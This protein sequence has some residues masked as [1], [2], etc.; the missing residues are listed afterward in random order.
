MQCKNVNAENGGHWTDRRSV[1]RATA[2]AGGK[3]PTQKDARSVAVRHPYDPDEIAGQSRTRQRQGVTGAE[4]LS[5]F[6]PA[7][8]WTGRGSECRRGL[9]TR[10]RR[11][12]GYQSPRIP[13]DF[14]T[15][16]LCFAGGVRQVIHGWR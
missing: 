5:V 14:R 11:S 8:I 4:S 7:N 2:D 10:P 3:S 12:V 13:R 15:S 1:S 9:V 16:S 6:L